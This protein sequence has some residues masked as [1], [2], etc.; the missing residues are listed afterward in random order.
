[1]QFFV[2]A[3]SLFAGLTAKVILGA[4]TIKMSISPSAWVFET[5]H[6]WYVACLLQIVDLASLSR[7]CCKVM[8]LISIAAYTGEIK[9]I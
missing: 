1:M 7:H 8:D 3:C 6:H 9:K 2:L 5:V 4:I